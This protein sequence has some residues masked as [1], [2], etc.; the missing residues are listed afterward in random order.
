MLTRK[1][2]QVVRQSLHFDTD[3]FTRGMK[4][5]SGETTLKLKLDVTTLVCSSLDPGKLIKDACLFLLNPE[6]L[7]RQHSGC[8]VGKLDF[9]HVEE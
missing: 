3:K 9:S 4:D 5:L 1:E 6:T 2:F 7:V 8:T